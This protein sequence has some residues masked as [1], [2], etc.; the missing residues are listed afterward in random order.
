MAFEKVLSEAIIQ[1]CVRKEHAWDII[2]DYARYPAI[3]DSVD[4][5]EI[6]ERTGETGTSKWQV[7][8]DSAPLYW[9]EKDFFNRDNYRIHFKS[10]EGDFDNI[11]GQWR[12]TD[13]SDSGI[14]VA[15]EVEYN[16]GI[17]VIEE[18]L[19]AILREK[20]KG[21]MAKMV[22]AVRKELAAT[23]KEERRF[24]RFTVNMIHTGRQQGVAHELVVL[25]LSAGGMMVR[26]PAK[27]L[28][29]GYLQLAV[30][31]LDIAE[32]QPRD[33]SGRCRLIFKNPLEDSVLSA[34]KESLINTGRP[35]P[36]LTTGPLEALV[37]PV[38]QEIFTNTP[39]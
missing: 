28:S 23:A 1:G 22:E 16:L 39:N 12:I 38:V 20:M 10:I 5:V 7:S 36:A 3:M 11:N 8:V 6:L 27:P 15:F 14:K 9:I 26:M 24:P 19:G 30:A 2:S 32:V 18:V 13:S 4:A 17:P 29:T 21:N 33:S 31:M 35:V 25:N 37:I 34:L